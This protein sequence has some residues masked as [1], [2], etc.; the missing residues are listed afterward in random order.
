VLVAALLALGFILTPVTIVA[1]FVHTEISDT[2][3][4]VQ[5]VQPLSADPAIQSYVADDVSR[6]LLG[7]VD[8]AAY[9]RDALPA[10]AQRLA[11]PMTDAF[12]GFVREATLR[13]VRSDQFQTLWTEANRLAHTQLVRVLTGNGNGAVTS[14]NGVVT[15]DLSSIVSQVQQRLESSGIDLFSRIPI[16]KI[17]GQIPVFESKDLYKAR[18]AVGV[19][20]TLAFVLP[21]AV[22]ACFGAAIYLSRS[23][24]RGFLAAALAF[25]AG[26]LVLSALLAVG[27]A[28]YLNAATNAELPHDAAAAVFDT[29]VRFLH[30]S[31]R[32]VATFSLIVIVAVFFAGPSRFATWSRL[33]VRTAANALGNASD[34]AGWGLLSANG[35]VVHRKGALRAIVAAVAFV[36]LFRW[37]HPTPAVIVWTGVVTLIALA[38][39]EYLGREP[40]PDTAATPTEIRLDDKA[41]PSTTT[42]ASH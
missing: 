8:V 37:P 14:Q 35:F 30:T 23:R 15:I 39:I 16:A 7:Q 38:I 36:I 20:D 17:G 41:R 3:R 33:R 18:H 42:T 5:N 4:Y 2:D 1:L 25:A 11:G 13:V 6:R 22:F 10:R 32:T 26:A 40:L 9:V 21:I 31:V 12:E 19:L 24:R 28:A 34:D 27:R 29:L